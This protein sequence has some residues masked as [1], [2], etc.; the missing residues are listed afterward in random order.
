MSHL[1]EHSNSKVYYSKKKRRSAVVVL[2]KC[3][4]TEL[5]WA[6]W[7]NKFFGTPHDLGPN[8]FTSS[9]SVNKY[10][11]CHTVEISEESGTYV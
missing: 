5:G 4:L 9:H 6:G 7:E 11:L 8:I 10:I 3:L 1:S 2:L